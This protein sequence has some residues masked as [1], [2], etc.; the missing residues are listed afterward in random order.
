MYFILFV[1]RFLRLRNM[2]LG[3]IAGFVEG[4]LGHILR[5][6]LVSYFH[7][8]EK[9]QNPSYIYICGV[10]WGLDKNLAFLYSP[11]GLH[12]NQFLYSKQAP[13]D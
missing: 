11:L 2:Q 13:N 7:P 8:K 10:K 9:K 6:I 5:C 3:I 4:H 1:I 12:A